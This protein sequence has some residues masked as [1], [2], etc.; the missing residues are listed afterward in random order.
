MK[1]DLFLQFSAAIIF[2]QIIIYATS[3]MS[4]IL[5]VTCLGIVLF[6]L[7]IFLIKSGGENARTKN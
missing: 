7:L 3:K 1:A 2:C 4:E 5:Q 6:V